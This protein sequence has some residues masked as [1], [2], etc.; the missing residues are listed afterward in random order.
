VSRVRAATWEV[1]SEPAP[2][3]AYLYEVVNDGGGCAVL[4]NYTAAWV[5]EALREEIE[6]VLD[7]AD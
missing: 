6:A 3:W 1:A 2:G 5:P 7:A 4:L